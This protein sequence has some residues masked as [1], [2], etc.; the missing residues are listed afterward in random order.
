MEQKWI[1]SNLSAGE[2]GHLF[3]AGMDTVALA[4]KYGTPLFLIDDKRVRERCREY[5]TAMLSLIHI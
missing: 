2:N 5:K 3:F 1:H 4:E